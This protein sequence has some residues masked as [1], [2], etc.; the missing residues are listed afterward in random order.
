VPALLAAVR[1]LTRVHSFGELVNEPEQGGVEL[2]LLG[3][4]GLYVPPQKRPQHDLDGVCNRPFKARPS[5]HTMLGAYSPGT[6]GS[7]ACGERHE[8]R[9]TIRLF[10]GRRD[11]RTCTNFR[12]QARKE[13]L[14]VSRGGLTSVSRH[15]GI[16]VGYGGA[17]M[18]GLSL[19][20]LVPGVVGGSETYARELTLALRGRSTFDYRVYVSPL[21]DGE[22]IGGET[23]TI[24]SYGGGESLPARA[25]AMARA[26]IAP[27]KIRREL[28]LDELDVVHF[29][30]TVML[31]TV[32][33]TPTVTSILDVQH[34]FFPE[35]FSR[36]ERTYRRALYKRS[37]R[38]SDYVVAISGHVKQT[39]V[40]RLELPAERVRVIHLGVDH[41]RFHPS[42]A[43][44]EPFILYPANLW[45]HKN[46]ARL[47]EA[48][49]LVKKERPELQ[50]VLTGHGHERGPQTPDVDRRGHVSDREL[51]DLY[52]RASALVFPSLYEGFGQPPIEAMAS[53]C[54]VAA[55]NAGALPEVCGDAAHLFDPRSVEAIASGVLAVLADAETYRARGIERASQFSWD[56]CAQEHEDLYR[57]LGATPA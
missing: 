34:E 41:E 20:T 15:S 57:E 6:F 10:R 31:P 47:L 53:G 23:T 36:A 1:L 26:A 2:A 22:R 24:T 51:A 52:R 18:V 50:L 16:V 55:S 56:R 39:L 40:D 49:A 5:C 54:P 33:G 48:F 3:Q 13:R 17:R 46:H 44:R 43:A 38:R 9:S 7:V 27:R 32:P 21:V 29:P 25:G 45:P 37:G 12:A 4:S 14:D 28:R 30:L 19:L 8:D 42:A 35:F 11:R